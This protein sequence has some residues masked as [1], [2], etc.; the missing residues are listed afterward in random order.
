MLKMHCMTCRMSTK[1]TGLQDL[2]LEEARWAGYETASSCCFDLFEE[3]VCVPD[4]ACMVHCFRPQKLS[5]SS[6]PTMLLT[7]FGSIGE[8]QGSIAGQ[9][10]TSRVPLG[11]AGAI[12]FS[13]PRTALYGQ[14]AARGD[15]GRQATLRAGTHG[16]NGQRADRWADGLAGQ[17]RLDHL[18]SLPA[19]LGWQDALPIQDLPAQKYTLPIMQFQS[20]QH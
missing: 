7:H 10:L 4:L 18:A 5:W 9:R 11:Y 2:M 12:R 16:R 3:R 1:G 6:L 14:G 15:D 8:L 17:K 19:T 20:L 13:G